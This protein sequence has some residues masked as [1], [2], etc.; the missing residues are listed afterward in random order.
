MCSILGL[1]DLRPHADLRALRPLALSLSALQRHRGPDWSGVHAEPRAL[2]V[3]E[4]L[5]IV[6]PAGGAQP[7]VSAD[8]TLVLA[9]NGEIY[10][11]ADVRRELEPAG[12]VYRTR[13]DT[14]TIVHA[15]EEWGD[16]CVH[17]FRGMFAFALWDSRRER[18]LVA[19]D[20]MGEKP[21]YLSEGDGRLEFA[22]ELKALLGVRRTTAD[23]DPTSI[24][25]FF[26][27]QYVPEPRT[28]VLGIRKLPAGH[29]L[30]I[31]V[32]PWSSREACYWRL[33]DAPALDATP[34][35][36]GLTRVPRTHG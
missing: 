7:I 32:A 16:D 6:D 33:E 36:R 4:R 9:V 30:V 15:Y 29:V 10:N 18:L 31:D 3:H 20:R 28:P 17:K 21:M 8:G 26:H 27:Y 23:L 12:H 22:S 19:R 11:H 35:T 25:L 5:A 34:A 24:D 14:E 2:L 1:F 13:S